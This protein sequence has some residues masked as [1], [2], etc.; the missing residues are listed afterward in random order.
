MGR[1]W[2]KVAA[3][4]PTQISG[5]RT[6]RPLFHLLLQSGSR[7]FRAVGGRRRNY[8]L[9]EVDAVLVFKQQPRLPVERGIAWIRDDVQPGLGVPILDAKGTSLSGNQVLTSRKHLVSDSEVERHC[10][11]HEGSV[12]RMQA[13]HRWK[14]G[15]G[16]KEKCNETEVFHVVLLFLIHGAS[17][18]RASHQ[19]PG[20]QR[21]IAL[22]G[23]IEN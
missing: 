19:R 14:N 16:R 17:A 3:L 15:C 9:E 5:V 13:R 8:V 20:S 11:F 23:V 21:S 4:L 7:E 2:L 12:L 22:D 10:S 6:V 18:A 1:T